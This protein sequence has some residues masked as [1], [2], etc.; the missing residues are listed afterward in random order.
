MFHN[1]KLTIVISLLTFFTSCNSS[2]FKVQ[3][4]TSQS[5]N[6]ILVDGYI[7]GAT[8]CL[9]YNENSLCESN[10]QTTLSDKNGAFS[11]AD[12][13]SKSFLHI[14]AYGGVDTSTNKK[15]VGKLRNI[16]KT[17]DVSSSN[18]IIV[19]PLTDFVATS[20]LNSTN[21]DANDLNDAKESVANI[22]NISSSQID[23]NPMTN[24]EVFSKAQEIQ[25]TKLFLQLAI[26]KYYDTNAT[27]VQDFVVADY[28]KT[29]LIFQGFNIKNFLTATEINLEFDFPQN[30]KTFIIEQL[31]ELRAELQKI[32]QDTTLDLNNLDRY[33][34]SLRN[35][36][37]EI[38]KKLQESTGINI[39][40]VVNME[41]TQTSV[42]QSLFDK[43]DAVFDKQACQVNS[44]FNVLVSNSSSSNSGADSINAISIQSEFINDIIEETEVT[45]FYPTLQVSK[46]DTNI[47]AFKDRHFFVFNNAWVDNNDN[48]IYIQTPKD[49]STLF[50]C[51]RF[52]LDSTDVTSITGEK[53]YAFSDI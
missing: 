46:G 47:I 2:S 30:E 26:N 28:I 5:I 27:Q 53:V 18:K 22:L 52:K 48:T 41:V 10:E 45:L 20:F 15:F 49:N 38:D 36:E 21:R 25:Y 37:D 14:L 23:L 19:S 6:G 17:A 51:H 4:I 35:K 7:S 3:A 32:S 9:D 43:T 29:N 44:N 13:D 39:I 40:D 31:K 33:Q 16:V 11:F 50:E 34:E 12:V 24:V 1:L 42:T 8:V